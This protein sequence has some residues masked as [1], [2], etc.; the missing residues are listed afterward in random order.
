MGNEK[1]IT[2]HELT[3]RFGD[4]IAVNRITFDVEKGCLLYTSLP[5]FVLAKREKVTPHF[6]RSWSFP[7]QQFRNK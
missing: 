3:K 4:F 1:V 2:A 7:L 6:R 5:A